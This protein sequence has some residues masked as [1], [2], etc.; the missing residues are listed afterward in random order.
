MDASGAVVDTATFNPQTGAFSL[1]ELVPKHVVQPGEVTF[2]QDSSNKY[3]GTIDAAG[4][5]AGTFVSKS[6]TTWTL[7]TTRQE[8]TDAGTFTMTKR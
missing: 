5:I 8:C 3:V 4:N 2:F 6:A 7:D 1:S